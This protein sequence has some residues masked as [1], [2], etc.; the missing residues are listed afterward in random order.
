MTKEMFEMCFEMEEITDMYESGY[1]NVYDISV[2]GN[3]TFLLADGIVSHNSAV[4]GTMPALGRDDYGFY[5][6]R[7]V[8]LNAYEVNQSKFTG[9]KELSEI[10]SIVQNECAKL[11][12]DGDFYE[13]EID[14]E[15]IIVNEYDKIF[16]KNK[17][18]NVSDIID[19]KHII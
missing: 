19:G 7:G 18:I 9:N 15:T 16:I 3:K 2:T 8:P 17:W 11:Y 10:Y 12:D 5:A 4:G 14:G 1:K 13:I 6:M